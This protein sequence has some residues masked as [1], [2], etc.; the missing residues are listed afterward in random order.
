MGGSGLLWLNR[1][2]FVRNGIMETEMEVARCLA[3]HV[4]GFGVGETYLCQLL[5]G[6]DLLHL[7]RCEL[8]ATE[9]EAELARLPFGEEGQ[10]SQSARTFLLPAS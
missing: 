7:S 5:G 8:V 9:L 3:L 6:H 1:T 2:K 10:L 4:F